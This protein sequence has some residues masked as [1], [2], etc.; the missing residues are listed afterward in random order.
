[1]KKKLL[2]ILV[3]CSGIIFSSI[4]VVSALTKK[5][6]KISEL[7]E[8][9]DYVILASTYKT[10]CI[11]GKKPEEIKTIKSYEKS[12]K[13][14]TEVYVDCPISESIGEV[15]T[16][17]NDENYFEEE[18]SFVLFINKVEN[19]ENIYTTV[20]GKSGIIK[21]KDGKAKPL[22]KSLK[23]DTVDLLWDW[24]YLNSKE[25]QQEILTSD[26]IYYFTYSTSINETAETTSAQ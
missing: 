26:G 2:F 7:D 19:E 9:A 25:K 8:K 24:A 12:G 17:V 18:G 10:R 6:I 23:L 16:I 22:N 21:F 4:C 3:L 15:I 14:Y 13:Y 20:N 1:M 11:Y 5:E